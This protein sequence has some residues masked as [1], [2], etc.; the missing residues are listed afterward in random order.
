MREIYGEDSSD[1]VAGG[2]VVRV[3]H[4]SWVLEPD[5]QVTFGRGSSSDITVADPR[6]SREH[7]RVER[8]AGV[9]T[10]RDLGSNNGTFVDGNQVEYFSIDRPMR[11]RLG[12]S[13]DG[14]II[15][16]EVE[17]S[18]RDVNSGVN[19]EV[20]VS[21]RH[22][23]ATATAPASSVRPVSGRSTISI[24]R[25]DDNDVVIRDLLASR[26]HAVLTFRPDGS[27]ELRDLK[28]SNGTYLDGTRVKEAVVPLG[29]T[30]LIGDTRLTLETGGVREV[31]QTEP[32]QF[33]IDRLSVTAPNGPKLVSSV[34]F[35]VP[36]RSLVGILGPSGA[37]KSSIVKA[38]VGA[39]PAEGRV[40]Y[41]SIDL[42]QSLGAVQRRIGYVPQDDILHTGLTVRR[43]LQHAAKLRLADD[44]TDDEVNGRV[45]EVLREL[46]LFEHD[47]KRIDQ[48]SGGQRKRVSVAMELL[49]RPPL[50]VLDEPSSGL[51]PGNEKSL[52]E[53]LR[54]L[55]K[56]T[57]PGDDGEAPD[58]R[59]LVVT[60]SVQSLELC[61]IVLVM[62]PG[63]PASPGGQLAYFGPPAGLCPHFGVDD[64]AE[65][66]R[67]LEEPTVD[68][69]AHFRTTN[70]PPLP[71]LVESAGDIRNAKVARERPQLTWQQQL[72]LL[73]RR[74]TEVMLAD[75]SNVRLLLAQAP[76]IGVMLALIGTDAF[77]PEANTPSSSLIIVL[78][79]LVLSITYLGASNSVREI[80][81]ERPV[82][83]RERALG[84]YPSAYLGS[85]LVVL[86]AITV[87]QSFLLVFIGLAS[88][89]EAPSG[90]LWKVLVSVRLELFVIIM[91]TGAAAVTLGLAISS[92]VSNA[93]K[94]MSL[95]PVVLLAMYLL[96]GG[97][98]SLADKPLL[99][100]V[101]YVNSAQWGYA[102]SAKV[103][104]AESLLQCAGPD[105]GA[106][107]GRA[108]RCR[109]AFERDGTRAFG[110]SVA[111]VV[112]AGAGAGGAVLALDRRRR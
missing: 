72:R 91:L 58:R 71:P 66:F 62:A 87:G 110:N 67:R 23:A 85:K 14:R 4:R 100:E 29:A 106:D 50:L 3:D 88:A 73:T 20:V 84:V 101:S 2:L 32:L 52:M 105:S 78:L 44:A 104:D 80:V 102:A 56:D 76:V 94:A 65:V 98:T 93:D 18:P 36:A 90:A 5:D 54:G 68:W 92:V 38:I 43:S 103:V 99:R 34:S 30:I 1:L 8:L 19:S 37:G 7:L 74:Y 40:L 45:D 22:P 97:P 26:H 64:P 33:F 24:G 77:E 60:H 86:L 6:V 39:L 81:K 69:P 47:E 27:A 9:W 25:A 57:S 46:G 70:P 16:V 48:L 31:E 89:G 10:A 53:L 49:T 95:L 75:G 112:L 11:L 109:D 12:S 41:G 108:A 13:K 111:L 21:D 61:D 107:P 82:F 15:S 63:S 51:D 79:G 59:V 35:E 96:S 28:S 55:A 83:E 42:L 17:G